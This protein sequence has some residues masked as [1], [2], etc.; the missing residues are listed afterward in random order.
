MATAG[1]HARTHARTPSHPDS[2]HS[3]AVMADVCD[4]CVQHARLQKP[5]PPRPRPAAPCRPRPRPT[6]SRVVG[7]VAVAIAVAAVFAV[8]LAAVWVWPVI[9]AA[10][11]L[12]AFTWEWEWPHA[13]GSGAPSDHHHGTTA[14]RDSCCV[15]QTCD[16][17]SQHSC[18][19]TC[20]RRRRPTPPRAC[21]PDPPRPRALLP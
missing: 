19:F 6:R 13:S 12:S 9:D 10:A 2:T 11:R 8:V 17:L 18:V 5:V 1:T 16:V 7:A 20:R 4:P 21:S 3:R 14:V 15:C